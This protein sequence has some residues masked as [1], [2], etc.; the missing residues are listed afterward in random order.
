MLSD[1]SQR[2]RE[3]NATGQHLLVESKETGKHT[4]TGKQF[5]GFGEV[6][7]ARKRFA[8]R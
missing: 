1:I 5:P 2:E 6:G 4:E 3:T 8:L 7:K